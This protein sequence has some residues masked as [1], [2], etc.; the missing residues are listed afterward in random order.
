M[1]RSSWKQ[2]RILTNRT[3]NEEGGE[4]YIRYNDRY[5]NWGKHLFGK[6]K[7]N[8]T[9]DKN[10]HT[11]RRREI[12]EQVQRLNQTKNNLQELRKEWKI[13]YIGK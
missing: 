12:I 5:G 1:E 4:S 7:Q 10:K 6:M 8:R 11:E 2:K 13:R 9:A 3:E